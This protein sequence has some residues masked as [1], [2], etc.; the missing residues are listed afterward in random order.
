MYGLIHLCLRDMLTEHLGGQAWER[1]CQVARVNPDAPIL[2]TEVYDDDI[3]FSLI[4]SSAD[5]FAMPLDDFLEEFGKAWVRYAAGSRYGCMLKACGSDIESLI[6]NLNGLHQ[7]VSSTLA[8]ANIGSF[9]I[10]SSGPGWLIVR[11]DS[12]RV[13]LERFVVGLMNGLLTYFDLL[14]SARI[15][16]YDDRSVEVL[17][18]YQEQS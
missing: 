11:Y 14:G 1:V 2:T 15:I 18:N 4:R 8:S 3:S 16:S 17:L 10:K 5:E 7:A 6:R 12:V 13:C 9:K